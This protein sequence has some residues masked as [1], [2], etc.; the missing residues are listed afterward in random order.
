[1]KLERRL[2]INMAGEEGFEPSLAGPE[3][4]VLP[5]DDPPVPLKNRTGIRQKI[6]S[7]LSYCLTVA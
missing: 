3:P 7:P 6:Q 1:V 4:A 5:L 2:L